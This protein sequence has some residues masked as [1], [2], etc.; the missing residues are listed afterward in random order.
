MGGMI[1]GVVSL[2]DRK[3]VNILRTRNAIDNARVVAAA[4]ELLAALVTMLPIMEDELDCRLRSYC[5]ETV[6]G[7]FDRS[8]LEV[9]DLAYVEPLEA[10]IADAKAAIAKA[11]GA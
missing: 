7:K 9:V 2:L 11:S 1:V 3:I 4:P 10:A 6:D 8:T 5:L